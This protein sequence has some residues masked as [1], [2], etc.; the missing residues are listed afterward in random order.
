MCCI[1]FPLL[2]PLWSGG[3]VVTLKAIIYSTSHGITFQLRLPECSEGRE[4][5][6][7]L[8]HSMCCIRA[9]QIAAVSRVFKPP[10]N[11]SRCNSLRR[12]STVSPLRLYRRTTA[13]T[14][15]DN[16]ED[17]SLFSRK[18]TALFYAAVTF[19]NHRRIKW[20]ITELQKVL[21]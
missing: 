8:K 13:Q 3:F 4:T 20:E 2:M 10:E 14:S 16:P 1:R 11:V 18:V 15:V 5:A 9:S 17:S 19:N 7:G 6:E 12:A 21:K